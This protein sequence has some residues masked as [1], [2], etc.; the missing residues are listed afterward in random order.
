MVVIVVVL[1]VVLV[2]VL[3]VVVVVVVVAIVVVA[4]VVV[5]VVVE[6]AAAAAA[7]AVL[8]QTSGACPLLPSHT[9]ISCQHT[10]YLSYPQHRVGMASGP[11]PRLA[12][13]RTRC[14]LEQLA[15]K[16]CA[17][18]RPSV[19]VV[20]GPQER[21]IRT[22]QLDAKLMRL[23]VRVHVSEFMCPQ[24]AGWRMVCISRISPHPTT[25][26]LESPP[27]YCFRV[28]LFARAREFRE[29]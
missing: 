2:L 14:R 25:L 15:R 22:K 26:G 29:P 7:A 12:Q 17:S 21:P 1:V 10:S 4:I 11:H 8:Q 6:A 23:P 27:H 28:R 9:V 13:T 18:R 16:R 20:I 5:T 19:L 24:R 3:V